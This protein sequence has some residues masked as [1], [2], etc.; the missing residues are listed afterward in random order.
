MAALRLRRL[1]V[2]ATN[3]SSIGPDHPVYSDD[4]R[5]RDPFKECPHAIPW[6]KRCND[7]KD[8]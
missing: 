1:R 8:R 4:A 6:T 5:E 2:R 3:A 7:C